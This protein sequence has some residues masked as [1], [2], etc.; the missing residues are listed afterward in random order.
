MEF[1]QLSARSLQFDT[2]PPSFP[3][4]SLPSGPVPQLQI[5]QLLTSGQPPD[6]LAPLQLPQCQSCP[7]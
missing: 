7:P 6:S 1:T 3:E 5:S 2:S 4:I